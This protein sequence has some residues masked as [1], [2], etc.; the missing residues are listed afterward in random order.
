METI[1]RRDKDKDNNIIETLDG[2]IHTPTK[3]MREKYPS[4]TICCYIS[5]AC[6][7]CNRWF[8]RACPGAR[9]SYRGNSIITTPTT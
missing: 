2:D 7:Y 9:G 8:E 1:K 6:E 3:E 5:Y 4:S